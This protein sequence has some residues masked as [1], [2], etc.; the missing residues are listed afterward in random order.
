M[1]VK[2][3]GKRAGFSFLLKMVIKGRGAGPQGGSFSIKL[4]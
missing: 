3:S 1:A 2:K 4:C